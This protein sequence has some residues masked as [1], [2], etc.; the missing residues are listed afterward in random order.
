MR[1]GQTLAAS[2][3]PSSRLNKLTK[4]CAAKIS[5]NAKNLRANR[6]FFVTMRSIRAGYLGFCITIT[7][8]P[9]CTC[10]ACAAFPSRIA[11]SN[12][13]D[14]PISASSAPRGAPAKL[15]C[16]PSTLCPL[17]SVCTRSGE[18]AASLGLFDIRD[19]VAKLVN[20]KNLSDQGPVCSFFR[21]RR[22]E[23]DNFIQRLA[24]LIQRDPIGEMCGNRR[25]NIASVK[26]I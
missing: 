26:C 17:I 18:N 4:A 1:A 23:R 15:D 19:E 22:G 9:T 16:K 21:C 6:R 7:R 5:R 8:S 13:H 3:G 20:I 10:N 11:I 14:E 24:H 2:S 12:C 25:E